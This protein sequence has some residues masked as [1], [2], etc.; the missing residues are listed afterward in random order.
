M[1][2]PGSLKPTGVL[3]L[4]K[5]TWATTPLLFVIAYCIL[6][7]IVMISYR[8]LGMILQA[9]T[10]LLPREC[11]AWWKP[12]VYIDLNNVKSFSWAHY[13]VVIMSAM[14][15]QITGVSIVC[16]SI[17]LSADLRKH[18]SSASLAFVSGIH[19]WTVDSPHAGP[20]TRKM[21]PFDDVIMKSASLS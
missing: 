13:G 3:L 14:A 9:D 6:L 10:L 4:N 15:S 2:K 8:C 20:V 1:T 18:Q 7:A 16:S 21:F 11:D 19:R 17:C 5:V 12:F